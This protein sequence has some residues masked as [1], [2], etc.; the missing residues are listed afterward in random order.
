MTLAAADNEVTKA[1]SNGA[2]C[3]SIAPRR[4]FDARRLNIVVNDPSVRPFVMARDDAPLD[5]TGLVANLRNVAL[6][7]DYG[8]LFFV[9]LAPSMYEVHVQFVESAR[10]A[11]AMAFTKACAQ[12][13][14]T[15]TDAQEAWMKVSEEN[16][17]VLGLIRALHGRLE[18]VRKHEDSAVSH[19]VLRYSDWCQHDEQMVSLG[20]WFREKLEVKLLRHGL[21]SAF[22]PE[23]SLHSA[24]GA[25]LATIR[26]GQVDKAI[27]FYN[28]WAI[29]SGYA[30]IT[31][32]TRWPLVL[33][34][35]NALVVLDDDAKSFE[36]LAKERREQWVS[37]QQLAAQA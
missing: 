20:E 15:R 27:T 25:T 11:W 28:R 32:L 18:F 1:K 13:M 5:L 26:G 31:L 9:Q 37:E 22:E 33:D 34:I 6:M 16:K 24:L 19:F 17:A 10:G 12:W 4:D 2:K 30:P 14:F 35:A 7:S 8:G 23:P 36:V 21:P 3:H 29:F